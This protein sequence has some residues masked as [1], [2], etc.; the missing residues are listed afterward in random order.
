MQCSTEP[1][2]RYPEVDEQALMAASRTISGSVLPKVVPGF[3]DQRRTRRSARSSFMM[4]LGFAT[5]AEPRS[6]VRSF[7]PDAE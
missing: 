1:L 4:A 5:F 3:R 2:A 6:H 7:R